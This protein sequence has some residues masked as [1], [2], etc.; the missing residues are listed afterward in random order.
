MAWGQCVLGETMRRSCPA[1]G[2]TTPCRDSLVV[3]CNEKFL[4]AKV[5]IFTGGAAAGA[6]GPTV[7]EW[8]LRADAEAGW[9]AIATA[10]AALTWPDESISR[11]CTVCKYASS[12]II[13]CQ[14]LL[15]AGHLACAR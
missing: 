4:T 14:F 5:A 1:T 12:Q 6:E 13:A 2:Y 7:L 11:A 10:A 3:T 15:S 9:A 8:L